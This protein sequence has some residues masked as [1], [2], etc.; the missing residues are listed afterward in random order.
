MSSH[1]E[2]TFREYVPPR[3][4]KQYFDVLAE[5]GK[6]YICI[7]QDEN[8]SNSIYLEHPK[9]GTEIVQGVVRVF[10]D[11]DDLMKYGRSVSAAEEIPFDLVR[12]WE[13]TCTSLID[14]V[15]KMDS[16]YKAAGKLGVRA[17]AS[18]VHG[19]KFI[20]LDTMWTAEINNMV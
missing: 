1:S 5:N 12:R 7:I 8:Q 19:D 13:M 3:L 18:A 9:D 6:V 10:F 4:Y 2:L 20:D 11:Q 15:S 16:K 14:Y 17:I